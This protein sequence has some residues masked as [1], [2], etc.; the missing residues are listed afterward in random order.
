VIPE[1]LE[2][3]RDIH[4]PATPGVWPPAIGWWMVILIAILLAF[5]SPRLTRFARRK[6][7]RR[8]FLK[9]ADQLK[10]QAMTSPGDAVA[11][12]SSLVRDVAVARF[13]EQKMAGVT[14]G[15][16]LEFLTETSDGDD[17]T[18]GAGAGLLDVPY[19]SAHNEQNDRAMS[20]FAIAER[21]VMHNA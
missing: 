9:R 4:A 8:R 5:F 21:W 11:G 13:P 12:L 10:Q 17:F 16:W 15:A 19:R 3:L 20:V 7:E 6:A 1:G 14:G 2:A 18:S